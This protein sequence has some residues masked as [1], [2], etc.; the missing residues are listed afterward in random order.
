M[1][2]RVITAAVG[3]VCLL[4]ATV[5]A[6]DARLK[7]ELIAQE[8][9]L[10]DALRNKDR[11]TVEEMLADQFYAIDMKYGRMETP[12][13]SAM[14]DKVTIT[15]YAL[16]EVRAFQITDDAAVL[17]YKY[18]WSGIDDGVSVKDA[19]SYATSTWA[20]RDGR[21]KSVFYQETPIPN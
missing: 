12:A 9:R 8:T 6:D 17:T 15:G 10:I 5:S 20:K 21:W 7:K 14:L 3:C 11:Q 18:V 4:S 1:F 16:S 2:V 13:V 19:K